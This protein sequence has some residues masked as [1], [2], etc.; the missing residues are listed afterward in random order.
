MRRLHSD[1]YRQ[2]CATSKQEAEIAGPKEEAGFGTVQDYRPLAHIAMW[3][4]QYDGYT[5]HIAGCGRSPYDR[6]ALWNGQ[7]ADLVN[8]VAAW[9]GGDKEARGTQRRQSLTVNTNRRTAMLLDTRSQ[10]VTA[11]LPKTEI[12]RYVT[13]CRLASSC[14]SLGRQYC[15]H[16][17]RI[18]KTEALQSF[19]TSVTTRHMARLHL[20]LPAT[21]RTNSARCCHRP[22]F[23]K[24]QEWTHVSS[25]N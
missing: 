25:A 10:D 12:I 8:V 5:L 11:L 6:P 21:D 2:G 22:S 17:E 20:R 19:E 13:P 7:V 4:E 24:V 16:T 9:G 15:L 14:R 18:T 1:T 3:W 23:Y